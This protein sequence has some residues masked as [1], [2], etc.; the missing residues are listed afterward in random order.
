MIVII[1][2]NITDYLPK[3]TGALCGSESKLA[4]SE[5]YLLK[6]EMNKRQEF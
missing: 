2:T 5:P 1:T 6:V 4:F 3:D